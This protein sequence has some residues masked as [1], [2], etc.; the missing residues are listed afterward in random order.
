MRAAALLLIALFAL[1]APLHA[2]RGGQLEIALQTRG[3][4]EANGPLV[5]TSGM[6]ADREMRGLLRSGFPAR[7]HFRV[8]LWSEAG[9]FNS[10]ERRV[11]WDIV[12]RQDPL[13]GSF[14]AV[15]V[16][17]GDT[18]TTS[19]RFRTVEDLETWLAFPYQVPV[20]ARGRRGRH[21]YNAVLDVE[22]LSL[23]DLDEVDR[24]LRGEVRPA[25]R[26]DRNP[27]TAI[28][29]GVRTLMVRLLGGER[30]HYEARSASFQP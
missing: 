10:L 30:R 11:E 16:V 21:Y 14:R 26:G 8:E 28:T 17:A 13:D 3:G 18:L 25:I 4:A 5:R 19:R 23:S 7:L 29:R 9:W 22:V 2:Q 12:I 15:R 1:S 27:T 24:W 6:I 20:S